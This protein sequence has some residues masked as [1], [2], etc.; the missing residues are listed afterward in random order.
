MDKMDTDDDL[1]EFYS[2]DFNIHTPVIPE[3][4]KFSTD[5]FS[6]LNSEKLLQGTLR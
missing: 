2:S 3:Y 5:R 4:G 6:E 1:A